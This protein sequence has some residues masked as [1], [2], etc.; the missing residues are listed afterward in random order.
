LDPFRATTLR[1]WAASVYKVVF[2]DTMLRMSEATTSEAGRQ[3]AA[4]RWGPQRPVKLARE[5]ASRIDELPA[6]ERA[7]LRA[8]LDENTTKGN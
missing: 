5:L 2:P 7:R 3:L 6:I 8:A 4:L 1:H